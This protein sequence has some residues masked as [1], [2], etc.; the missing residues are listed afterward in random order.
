MKHSCRFYPCK[1]PNIPVNQTRRLQLQATIKRFQ[2]DR[3]LHLEGQHTLIKPV[4]RINTETRTAH[5]QIRLYV[6]GVWWLNVMQFWRFAMLKGGSDRN[7]NIKYSVENKK[8]IKDSEVIQNLL[9]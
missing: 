8:T 1:A 2:F 9:I 4:I 3:H 6:C 5:L 7:N